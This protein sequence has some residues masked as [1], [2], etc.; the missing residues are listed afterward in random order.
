MQYSHV[1]NRIFSAEE[2]GEDARLSWQ[3]VFWLAEVL[4]DADADMYAEILD[5]E[6]KRE[7]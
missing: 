1:V 4:R 6:R 2:R 7:E 3:E 5:E